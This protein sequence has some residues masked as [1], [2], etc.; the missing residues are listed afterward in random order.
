MIKNTN[1]KILVILGP[2]ASGKSDLAVNLAKKFNG[3]IISADSRQ[4]YKGLDLGSGKVPI[5]YEFRNKRNEFI[6]SS[7]PPVSKKGGI[8]MYYRGIEHHLIDIISPKKTFTVSQY[9]KIGQKTIKNILEKNKLPIICG[10]TGLYIDSL[11]YGS[12]FPEVPPQPK[13]RKKLEKLSSEN[14][15]EKLEKLDPQRAKNI[16]RHNRRR[17]IRALEIVI[18]TG[19][20]VP[21]LPRFSASSFPH[22]SAY[23]IIG[24]KKSQ[25]ELKKL[26]EKRLK[27]R[28]KIGMI[29]EVENLH[30]N[31]LSWKR[32][33]DF[34]LEYRFISRYL[35][36]L[37]KINKNIS[38]NQRNNLYKSASE[39]MKNLIIKESLAYAKRQMT[40]FKRNAQ[41][42]WI[43]KKSD[44]FKLT[45]KFLK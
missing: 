45:K 5:L 28:L 32:L 11:I 12:Q 36:Q 22:N 23:L 1:N 26:I 13:L 20:P 24:I 16:D 15:F 34:G 6:K 43:S 38:I 4:I 8:H 31:G 30:K 37:K 29:K 25:E 40:W 9:Q 21:P 3:E 35:L 19:K 2:T 18:T 44:A 39:E 27:K 41:I 7:I 17:L 14:L 33:D 10:G 42:H